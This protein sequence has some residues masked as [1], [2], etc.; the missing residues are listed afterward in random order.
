MVA[1][2][3][4]AAW[5]GRQVLKGA[6]E[7]NLSIAIDHTIAILPPPDVEQPTAKVACIT[8]NHTDVCVD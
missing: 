7:D 3:E 6:Q 1:Q 2:P 4:S 5:L 8:V